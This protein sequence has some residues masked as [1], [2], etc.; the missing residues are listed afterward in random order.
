MNIIQLTATEA[1]YRPPIQS[2][3]GATPPSGYAAVAPECDTSAMQTHCGH[4]DLTIED[5][6][7]TAITGNDEAYQAYLDSLP[8]PVEP[9]PT[10]AQLL[11]QEITDLQLEQISQGQWITELELNQLEGGSTNNA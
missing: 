11:G 4:V 2:W 9:E 7:V 8:P 3:S 10:E 1:G 6:V 5:S